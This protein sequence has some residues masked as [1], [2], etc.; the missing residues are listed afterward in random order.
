MPKYTSNHKLILLE[1]SLDVN[2]APIPFRFS[3]LW[4][5]QEGFQEVVSKACNCQVQGSPFFLC[6]EKMRRLKRELKEWAKRLKTPTSKRK[7]MHDSLVGHQL[8]MEKHDVTQILLKKEVEP[9]KYLHRASRDE[10]ELWRQKSRNLWLQA[11]DKST[12]CFHKQ[13]EARKHFKTVNEIHYQNTI[14]KDF[15][16]IKRATHSF[17]KDIYSAPENPPI[18]SQVYANDLIP[19]CV[20][21]SHNIM[22]NALISMNVIKEA[23]D[24]MDLDKASGP[25][26]FTARFYLTC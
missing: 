21:D 4:I 7:E 17:F 5:H 13:A 18:D 26:G 12:S 16:G 1:L 11:E 19:Q 22:M 2:L 23:F 25:N 24:C 10:E 14:V 15:E 9:Q 20:Q 3:S 6:E 8:T